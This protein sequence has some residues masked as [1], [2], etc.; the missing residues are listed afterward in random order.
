MKIENEMAKP[1]GEITQSDFDPKNDA[2]TARVTSIK[3]PGHDLLESYNPIEFN[4]H[5]WAL[6]YGLRKSTPGVDLNG[7]KYAEEYEAWTPFRQITYVGKTREEAIAHM[8]FGVA[9]LARKGSF[10]PADPTAKGSTP[11]QHVMEVL[12]ERLAWHLEQRKATIES[13]R[14]D[15]GDFRDSDTSLF[16]G[17]VGRH[18]EAVTSLS[19]AIAALARVK[20]L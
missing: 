14:L 1:Q 5:K 16:N 8:L 13:E 20:D 6:S 18:N 11:I 3:E 10:N 9:E 7:V 12:H 17:Q 15:K 2:R 4:A 19:T